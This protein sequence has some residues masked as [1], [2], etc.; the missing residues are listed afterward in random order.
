MLN[1]RKFSADGETRRRPDRRRMLW[2]LACACLIG[3]TAVAGN[4]QNGKTAGNAQS[5]DKAALP[6]TADTAPGATTQ[7]E[8]RDE[9]AGQQ[10]G[11]QNGQQNLDTPG[12]ERRKQIA[13]ES[14][15]LVALA[16]D[17]KTEVDKTNRDMLS[18]AVIRKAEEIEKL[19]H[20]VKDK[21]KAGGS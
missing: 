8:Q 21:L 10:T 9:K 6:A 18:V 19:A 16:T 12:A 15:Q 4:A 7:A 2:G 13:D 5:G 3:L 11:Q 17:L 20:N 1:H 14:S